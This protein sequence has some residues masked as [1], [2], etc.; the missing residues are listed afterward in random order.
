[1]IRIKK[2]NTFDSVA[3]LYEGRELTLNAF[4]RGLFPM[5]AIQRKWLKILRSK[6]ML[7]SLPIALT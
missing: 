5:K 4:R 3:A 2:Q 6:Q 7:Q 1:M